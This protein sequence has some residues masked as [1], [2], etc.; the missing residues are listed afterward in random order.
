MIANEQ[1]IAGIGWERHSAVECAYVFDLSKKKDTAFNLSKKKD[2]APWYLNHNISGSISGMPE[3]RGSESC[4][5]CPQCG[6]IM[7]NKN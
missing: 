6:E 7:N 3:V 2:T 1:K 5:S 4:N